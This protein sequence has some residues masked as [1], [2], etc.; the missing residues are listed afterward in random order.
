MKKKPVCS[1]CDDIGMVVIHRYDS[2]SR[3]G[4]ITV[5]VPCPK[6]RPERYPPPTRDG[7][8]AAAGDLL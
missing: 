1:N 4:F 8:M 6:C 3:I 5:A 7:K 2:T